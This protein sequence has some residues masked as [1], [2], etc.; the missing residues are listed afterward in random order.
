MFLIRHP[1]PGNLGQSSRKISKRLPEA[2]MIRRATPNDAP[3]IAT[4]YRDTVKKIKS[5]DYAPAQI[6]AWAG[7]APDEEKWRE[8]QTNRTTFV[9]EHDGTVRGFGELEDNGHI[10]AVYVHADW[11]GEGIASALLN[12]MEKEAV[13]HGVTSLST[14]A[15]ITAQPFFAKLGFETLSAQ[16]VEYRG[17][18]FR[19]Y[20]MRKTGLTNR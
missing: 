15:S 8:R 2:D 4:L 17:Q 7:A 16:D 10:G 20:R 13:A 14:E 11:Q 9:D 5:H 18:L 6:E 12:E 3:A 19:N 1:C